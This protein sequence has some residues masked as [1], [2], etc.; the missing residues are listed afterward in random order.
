MIT[1][2]KY[3]R[4]YIQQLDGKYAICICDCGNP[5]RARISN[6]RSGNTTSCGCLRPER[7]REA[8]IT[9]KRSHGLSGTKE[10]D[11]WRGML[12]GSEATGLVFVGRH[13]A[14]P[15]VTGPPM[16]ERSDNFGY[17]SATPIPLQIGC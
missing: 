7:L 3:G 15:V 1:D 12:N 13:F 4:L 2:S 9:K 16:R 17:S 10:Y 11:C 14:N 5:I 6:I 8:C